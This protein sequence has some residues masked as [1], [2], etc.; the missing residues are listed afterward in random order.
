[1]YSLVLLKRGSRM[2]GGPYV[3][4]G[5]ILCAVGPV[6]FLL[7]YTIMYHANT[8]CFPILCPCCW[9]G[10]FLYSRVATSLELHIAIMVVMRTS[11]T[12]TMS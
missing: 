9:M 6:P 1:M 11:T 4:D 7:P 10:I 12:M 3:A 8:T 2:R 5:V